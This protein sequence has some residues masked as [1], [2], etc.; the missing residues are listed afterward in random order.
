M[1]NDIL[2]FAEQRN[3]QLH[4][5]ALQIVTPARDLAA[6]TGGQVVACL[7]G[8]KLDAATAALDKAGVNRI[9]TTSAPA[10]GLYSA[11]RYRTALTAAVAKVEP[12]VLL[13]PATFMG[14]DLGA[15]VAARMQAAVATDVV[16]LTIGA[17]G[18][19][20]VRRPVY[21]GKAFC[22]VRFPKDRL[23]VA[24]VRPNS[25]PAATGGGGAARETLAYAPVAGDDRIDVKELAKAGG[26]VKDVT[27]ADII[28]SGG[29]ALK[30]EDNFRIIF[31]L[32]KELD[33]AV[34]ASRAACD[35]GY[36]PHSR[37]VGLTGKTV[38]PRLYIACGI[39]GAIQHLAGMRGSKVI[40]AINTDKEA[41]LF[42]IAD[43]G[44]VGDL[45]KV[46]PAMTAEI[47]KLKG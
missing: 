25:F 22:H 31:E 43:Y 4:P 2:I 6:K 8:D 21:N 47:K 11:L 10:L 17:D 27:E 40:V 39:S 9:I 33:A 32:A 3:D 35:A 19:L 20:D 1:S 46:V 15:R 23:A 42:K 13:L 36:Q 41:P 28:V 38:T 18:G 12:R 7:I 16:E 24:T 34:G 26:T 30:N 14:R 44:I 37:Q 29:R 5:T 45:F